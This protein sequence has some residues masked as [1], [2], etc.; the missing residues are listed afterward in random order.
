MAACSSEALTIFKRTGAYIEYTH[1]VFTSG[2]HSGSYINKDA[3][4]PHTAEIAHLC[5]MLAERFAGDNIEVVV[6]PAIGGVVLTQ[7]MA[8]HLSI[9]TGREVLAIYGEKVE[10]TLF[11][12]DG[13]GAVVKAG[14]DVW[15]LGADMEVV[16]RHPSKFVIKRGY[17]KLLLRKRCLCIEDIIST[18]GSAKGV[19]EVTRAFG[20]VVVGLGA[21][22]N[23]GGVTAA[24]AGDPPKFISLVDIK[25]DMWDK[26][27]CP[28]CMAQEPVN[29]DIGHGK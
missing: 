8:Y 24:Q 6:G 12:T 20:G 5:K 2:K 1:A 10:A 3:V 15:E 26:D 7:W 18:G 27:D 11:K 4:Y 19:I 13:A 22:W 14:L 17:E 28:L 23:R 29:I 25:L 16:V 9:L 21:L